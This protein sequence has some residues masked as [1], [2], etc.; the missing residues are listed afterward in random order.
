MSKI[1]EALATLIVFGLVVW[2]VSMI[3]AIYKG[4]QRIARGL[5]RM[6]ET[7]DG[8]EERLGQVATPNGVT[9]DTDDWPPG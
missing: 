3:W 2:V 5:A 4:Q 8:M 6:S 9:D 7:L 1:F